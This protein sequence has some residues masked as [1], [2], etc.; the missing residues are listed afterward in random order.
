M[1]ARLMERAKPLKRKLDEAEEDEEVAI[2]LTGYSI[3]FEK[4]QYVKY[5]NVGDD[6]NG[7]DDQGDDVLSTNKFVIFKLCNSN[8]CSLGCNY[9]YAEYVV[10]MDTYIQSMIEMKNE[11]IENMCNSCEENCQADDQYGNLSDDCQSCMNECE[12][13]ENLEDNGYGD[14]SQFTECMGGNGDDDAAYYTGAYCAD[15]GSKIDIGVFS[16]ENCVYSVSG[17][18][19]YEIQGYANGFSDHLLSA[20]YSTD[21]VSCLKEVNDDEDQADDYEPETSETCQELYDAAGKC[22]TPTSFAGGYLDYYDSQSANEE[23][24]C[25]FISSLDSGTYDETGEIVIGD[26]G[27]KTMK[28]GSA[29]TG[30]QKFFLTVLILTT[31]GLAGH[32]VTI[33]QKITGSSSVDLTKQGGAIA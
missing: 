13:Y 16:D 10:D 32:A 14:A 23:S 5:Y 30:G 17:M 4:C 19:A 1:K 33:H 11:S 8:S 15:D 31:L 26:G 24:V 22:E 27:V 9:D 20:A 2:D 3:V 7:G 29:A 21:C 18:N 25:N 28:G 6:E 12:G